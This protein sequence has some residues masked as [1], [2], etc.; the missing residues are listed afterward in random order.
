MAARAVERR[1]VQAQA[2]RDRREQEWQERFGYLPPCPCPYDP[3]PVEPT[4]EDDWM[5][6]SHRDHWQEWDRTGR[7]P[8]CDQSTPTSAQA[9]D[10]DCPNAIALAAVS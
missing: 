3:C 1:A 10:H 5:W 7:C 4:L 6:Q 9:R 2:E 8:A